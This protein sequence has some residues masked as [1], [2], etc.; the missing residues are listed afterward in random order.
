MDFD[1]LIDDIELFELDLPLI[2]LIRAKSLTQSSSVHK[3][4]F[5]SVIDGSRLMTPTPPAIDVC[6]SSG[7]NVVSRQSIELLVELCSERL[8]YIYDYNLVHYNVSIL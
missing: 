5:S 6:K 2:P 1:E 3:S 8:F 7:M 4:A